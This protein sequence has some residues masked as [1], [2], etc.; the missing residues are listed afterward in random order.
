MD[1]GAIASA[2]GGVVATGAVTGVVVID[3]VCGAGVVP[4]ATPSNVNEVKTTIVVKAWFR[5]FAVYLIGLPIVKR[6]V[7]VRRRVRRIVRIYCEVL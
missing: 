7:K 3:D 5:I 6:F 2:P 4:Q 1:V